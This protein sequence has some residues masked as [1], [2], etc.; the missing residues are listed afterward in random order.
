MER[1]AALAGSV[2]AMRCW[3]SIQSLQLHTWLEPQGLE[4]LKFVPRHHTKSHTEHTRA[5]RDVRPPAAEHPGRP[6]FIRDFGMSP[7]AA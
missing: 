5:P 2:R 6:L 4:G 3:L 1:S 7:L